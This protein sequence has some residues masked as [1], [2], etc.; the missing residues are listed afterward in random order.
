MANPAVLRCGLLGNHHIL[1]KRLDTEALLPE[2]ISE[3]LI[4][5]EEEEIIL[6][7]V[8]GSQKTDRLLSILHR[9]G[10]VDPS[11][12]KKF[13]ELL[14]QSDG[15][16]L[17]G[18][19]EKIQRDSCDDEVKARFA[20]ST[21]ELNAREAVSLRNLEDKIVNALTVSEV[22]PQLISY[23]IV[24]LNENDVIR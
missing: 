3:G 2:L 10:S 17:R 16:L 18:D 13:F 15:Q 12:Y 11:V 14:S 6:H 8:T 22:L 21:G 20:Y 1:T 19:L 9:R 5:N 24:T 7:E 23:G 4:S